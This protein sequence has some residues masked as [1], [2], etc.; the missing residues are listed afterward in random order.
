MRGV[1]DGEPLVRRDLVGADDPAHLVV[2]DLC[3][4]PR[5]RTEPEV[6]EVPEVLRKR[7]AER[8]GA[9][10]DLERRERV[11]VDLRHGPLDRPDDVRVVLARERRMDPALQADLRRPALPRLL[12]A[13]HDLVERDEVRRAAQV[14]RELPLRERAEAAAEVADVR[15]LDVP[16]HDV[17]DLVAADLPPKG[18]GGGADTRLPPPRAPRAA[19]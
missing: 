16:G 18:I 5:E 15:V 9:L 12:G 10:P 11:H 1:V 8:R 17:G 13:P 14:R 7:E 2:E 4:R 6:A 19:A 3:S